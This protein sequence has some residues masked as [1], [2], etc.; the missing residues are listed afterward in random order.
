MNANMEIKKIENTPE[1]K[2]KTED[3]HDPIER[4]A[5]DIYENAWRYHKMVTEQRKEWPVISRQKKS[6]DWHNR[7]ITKKSMRRK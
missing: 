7:G 5:R 2:F 3:M 4:V 6:V 1:S